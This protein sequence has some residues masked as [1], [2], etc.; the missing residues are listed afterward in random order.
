MCALSGR[1]ARRLLDERHRAAATSERRKS[2]VAPAR[3]MKDA[4][5]R[6]AFTPRERRLVA[7]LRTPLAVQRWLNAM[8]Y[9]WERRGETARTF[10]GVVRQGQAHCLEAALSAATILEQHGYPPLLMDIESTDRLDHVLFLFRQNGNWGTVARSRC[11]GLHGRKPVYRDVRTLVQSYMAPYIDP[12][13]RIKGYGVL[14]LRDLPRG[15]WRLGARH[16]FF[17]E[18]AL[19]DNRH[20]RLP[21]PDA[22]FRRWKRRFDGWW[23]AHGRPDHE[24]PTYYPNRRRWM[25]P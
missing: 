10:R 12:T 8:S 25:W 17:I 19:N 6:S 18:D 20:T 5:P 7:R 13:G 9:N 15:D 1:G 4:P 23:E 2:L 16:A 11:P 3:P 22:Y 14:D 21:T 24:W